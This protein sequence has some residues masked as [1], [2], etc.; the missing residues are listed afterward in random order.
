MAREIDSPM[1]KKPPCY[2]CEEKFTACHGNCPKDARGEFG[3][4]TWK[5]VL[6]HVNAERRKYNEK[7]FVQYNPFDY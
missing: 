2:G 5:K 7:P 1:R 3:Y 6:E 4:G